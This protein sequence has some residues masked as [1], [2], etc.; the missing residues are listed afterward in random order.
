MRDLVTSQCAVFK[1]VGFEQDRIK[2]L[3]V[4]EWV[5]LHPNKIVDFILRM[6]QEEKFRSMFK[7]CYAKLREIFQRVLTITTIELK[8]V[9]EAMVKSIESTL[10]K[11][12]ECLEKAWQD[13]VAYRLELNFWK[14]CWL[15][16][17]ETLLEG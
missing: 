3:A 12:R 4:F 8:S 10:V 14:K 1:S 16:Q 6:D 13:V 7:G 2:S 15:L 17:E 11:Q 9:D 5:R